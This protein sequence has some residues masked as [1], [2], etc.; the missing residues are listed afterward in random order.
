MCH[1]ASGPCLCCTSYTDYQHGHRNRLASVPTPH[2]HVHGPPKDMPEREDKHT[3]LMH[4]T[5]PAIL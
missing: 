1:G 4:L 5:W 3:A 2:M